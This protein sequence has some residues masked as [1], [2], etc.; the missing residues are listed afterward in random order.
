MFDLTNRFWYAGSID[1]DTPQI[2]EMVAVGAIAMVLELRMPIVF[3]R[4]RSGA[5]SSVVERSRSSASR[6]CASH[7]IESI[8]S[9]PL[10][11][12]EPSKLG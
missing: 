12:S 3:T 1:C 9:T 6:A 11:H 10:D 2:L 8:G 7:S 5:Q 4:S